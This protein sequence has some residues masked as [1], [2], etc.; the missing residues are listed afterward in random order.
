MRVDLKRQAKEIERSAEHGIRLS[1]TKRWSGNRYAMREVR[2]LA[3]QIQNVLDGLVTQGQFL[4]PR[5]GRHISPH[6]VEKP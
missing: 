5:K 2:W 3:Q 6:R 1:R 4:S